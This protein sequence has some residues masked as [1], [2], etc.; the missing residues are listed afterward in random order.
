MDDNPNTIIKSFQ[1]KSC[2]ISSSE[3]YGNLIRPPK[4]KENGGY[5]IS[6]TDGYSW[7]PGYKN[8]IEDEDAPN[9]DYEKYHND[10]YADEKYVLVNGR[11]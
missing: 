6:P 8:S 10:V 1:K 9:K 4:S 3:E 2:I 7:H 5:T 11:G